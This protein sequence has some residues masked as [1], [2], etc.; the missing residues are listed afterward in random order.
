[1]GTILDD[2]DVGHPHVD[3]KYQCLGWCGEEL[4]RMLNRVMRRC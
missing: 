1:M 4:F 3:A 2:D